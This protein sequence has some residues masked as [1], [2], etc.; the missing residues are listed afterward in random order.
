MIDRSPKTTLRGKLLRGGA[1]LV[2]AQGI[3]Q[4]C[5]FL[6]NIIV[7][8][9]IGVEN[10]GIASVFSITIA[11]FNMIGSLSVDRLL[12][13]AK[14]GN[15]E[16]FQSAAH[17]IQ[18]LRGVTSALLIAVC[19]GPIASLFGVPQAT[20][21]FRCLALVPLFAGF[22]HLDNQRVQ[23]EFKYGR[24][25]LNDVAQRAIPALLAWPVAM[26]IRDYSAMLWLV[27]LQGLLGM[28]GSFAVAERRYR[29]HWDRVYIKRFLTFGFPL[30]ANAVLLFGIYQG[31]RFL[32][33][34]AA[35]TVGS[36]IYTLKDLGV[37]SAAMSL[38]LTPMLT[39]SNISS[40]LL[41]PVFSH[42][43]SQLQEFK[44]RYNICTQLVVLVSGFLT[45]PMILAGRWIVVALYGHA[46]VEA[47][48][49]IG[50]LA[51]GQ[52]VRMARIPPTI[53]AMAFGDTTNA[54][55]SNLVRFSA[56]I[57]TFVVIVKGGSLAWIAAFGCGGEV[58]GL[59]VC[60][61]KLQRD[62][63]IPKLFAVKAVLALIAIMSFAGIASPYFYVGGIAIKL[64]LG[65]SLFFGFLGGMLLA[66]PA[67]RAQI[68][69]R[70]LADS[71]DGV[72]R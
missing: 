40:S 45:L 27:L 49:F 69:L 51:A 33:G 58:L 66:F 50:W 13:Q 19:A 52:A 22:T 55:F 70:F 62:H 36:H 68:S 38:T 4:G 42:F 39:L 11:I 31:D 60:L 67:L 24:S 8:R 46:Y 15:E 10:F 6:Q 32:I 56:L 16:R 41:L 23:R 29:W 28:C 37:Y 63:G 48:T 65:A 26:W 61:W 30:I 18:S 2:A 14:D 44:R 1:L 34:T 12:I 64:V 25:V 72:S 3:I 54:M 57:G 5:A 35:K 17:A 53:A 59:V 47:G 21:A 20:W 9:V 7:A 71:F 43:Q